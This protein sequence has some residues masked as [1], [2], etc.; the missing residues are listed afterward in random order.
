MSFRVDISRWLVSALY[1]IMMIATLYALA[2]SSNSLFQIVVAL[3][4]GL[5]GI[6]IWSAS[7]LSDVDGHSVLGIVSGKHAL[8]MSHGTVV[9]GKGFQQS[10][11]TGSVETLDR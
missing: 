3:S 11:I 2:T 10:R 7:E 9:S 8:Y 6:A 5:T 4:I 1:A